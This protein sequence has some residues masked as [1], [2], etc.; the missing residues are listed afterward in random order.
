MLNA[1]RLLLHRV[2]TIGYSGVR[3]SGYWLFGLTGFELTVFGL[4]VIRA[5]GFRT[6]G[7]LPNFR[8]FL[9]VKKSR[10]LAAE[11]NMGHF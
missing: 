10:F 2:R 1:N 11:S 9:L 4:L 6:S 3:L 5:C 8:A 7:A